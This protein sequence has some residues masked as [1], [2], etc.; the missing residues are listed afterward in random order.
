MMTIHIKNL[1]VPV[2]IGVYESE[3]LEKQPIV[4]NMKIDYD[5][6]AA[7]AS[8]RIGDALNYHELVETLKERL[9][10]MQFHLLEKFVDAI[11]QIAMENQSVCRV[12]VE[13]DKPNA[14][15]YGIES[16]SITGAASR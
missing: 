13:I 3:R 4:I 2:L 6:S 12:N 14:P 1:R 11:L 5:E 16:V 10:R 9:E 7:L 8:D 15:I